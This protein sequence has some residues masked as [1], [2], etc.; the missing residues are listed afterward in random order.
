MNRNNQSTVS[1]FDFFRSG[2]HGDW[3][4]PERARKMAASSRQRPN[5]YTDVSSSATNEYCTSYSARINAL[6]RMY[7]AQERNG[8]GIARSVIGFR[9]AVI[10]GRGASVKSEDREVDKFCRDYFRWNKLDGSGFYNRVRISEIEG[11]WVGLL[12]MDGDAVKA[13]IY[14]HHKFPHEFVDRRVDADGR[15]IKIDDLPSEKSE[16]KELD[17]VPGELIGVRIG[18]IKSGKLN[19]MEIVTMAIVG[20]FYDDLEDSGDTPAVAHNV[21]EELQAVSLA[22][23][24]ARIVNRNYASPIRHYNFQNIDVMSWIWEKMARRRHDGTEYLD[25]DIGDNTAFPGSVSNVETSGQALGCL[26]REQKM[27]VY[28]ISGTTKI[29]IMWLGWTSE[30]SNRATA[31]ELPESLHLGTLSERQAHSGAIEDELR[32]AIKIWNRENGKSLDENAVIKV[33]IPHVTLG[34]IK[35]VAETYGNLELAGIISKDT[36]RGMIPIG[37]PED[38]RKKIEAEKSEMKDDFEIPELEDGEE[39]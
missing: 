26:D 32:K 24:D 18:G 34:W 16:L 12:A 17:R 13:T 14:R 20:G 38:E 23:I 33:E 30:L 1:I 21:I 19:P 22:Q 9:A 35:L 15:T 8:R 3:K 6:T 37:N 25:Y 7:M 39:Q 2:K 29:P 36:L 5:P 11:R 31:T 4:E 27:A 10:G 28:A